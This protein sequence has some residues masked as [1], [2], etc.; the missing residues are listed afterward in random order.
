[1]PMERA[2]QPASEGSAGRLP[3]FSPCGSSREV[4]GRARGDGARCRT[5]L[6]WLSSPMPTVIFALAEGRLGGVHVVR[7][8]GCRSPALL[9]FLLGSEFG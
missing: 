2:G 1:M 8:K 5:G 9:T 3:S 6:P 7:T 4:T